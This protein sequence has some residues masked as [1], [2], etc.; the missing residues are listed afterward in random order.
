MKCRRALG[1]ALLILLALAGSRYPPPAA[2]QGPT[3]APAG[4]PTPHLLPP[5]DEETIRRLAAALLANYHADAVGSWDIVTITGLEDWGIVAIAPHGA[6]GDADIL[7]AHRQ[8]GAWQVALPDSPAFR[9]WLPAVPTELLVPFPERGR[10]VVTPEPTAP[11]LGLYKLPYLCGASAYASRAGADHNNAIDFLI[12]AVSGTDVVVAAEAGWVYRIAQN[13]TACCCAAGYSSNSVVI[14]HA[15]GEYSYYL[16]LQAG[17]VLVQPG[18]Q[19]YQG[20]PIALEGD[21]GYTCSTATGSCHSRFCDVPGD[22]D[23][24]CE[25][26][27]FEVRTNGDYGGVAL[28]PRFADVAGEFVQTGRTYTSGN[29]P[30]P[31]PTTTHTFS[32]TPGDAP[33]FL[34]PVQVTLTAQASGG[35]NVLAT[36]YRL[37]DSD[38]LP[39]AAPFVVSGEGEHALRYYSVDDCGNQETPGPAVPLGIDLHDP[40]NPTAAAPGCRGENNL[41]QDRCADASFTWSGAGDIGSGLRDYALYWGPQPQGQPTAYVTSPA[42]DPGPVPEGVPYFLRLSARDQAGRRA[43]AATL[44]VLRYDATPPAAAL[45]IAGGLSTTQQ[46]A[47]RLDI[48]AADAG[49]G[50]AEMRLSDNGL[51]W[52]AWQPY[53]SQ[54]TWALPALDGRA[55]TVSLQVRDRAGNVGAAADSIYLDLTPPPPHSPGFRLCSSVVDMGGGAGFA[56]PGFRLTA[57]VGQ[58][59]G[60]AAGSSAGFRAGSGFLAAVGGCPPISSSAEPPTLTQGVVAAGGGLRSGSTYRLGDTAG[61]AAVSSGAASSSPSYRLAGGFWAGIG[62]A[63]PPPPTLPTPT[64]VFPPTL[65]PQPTPTRPPSDFGL[66]INDGAAFTNRAAVTLTLWAPGVNR[67]RFSNTADWVGVLWES[68]RPTHTWTISTAGSYFEPRTVFAQ[69]RDAAGVVYGDY[70]DGILYDPVPPTGTVSIVRWGTLTATVRLRA[71]DDNSGVGWMRLAGDEPGL[72]AAPWEPFAPT[73]VVTPTAGRVYAQFR[74]RAGNLSAP[75]SAGPERRVYLPL[76]ER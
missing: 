69:F 47:V 14:R 48:A 38:W 76:V 62:G 32:G 54:S 18:A 25:H 70:Q 9:A 33:W 8:D 50:P 21:V 15:N 11:T 13:Y 37:D 41:W 40:R 1:L 30:N 31:G 16:H 46:V 67:A 24:C 49:S 43:P 57:A 35:C 55:Y 39:Y 68:H 26:L 52:S 72:I 59:W 20:Q 60:G 3:P 51:D 61:E 71:G 66:A 64:P 53:A 5:A 56:S 7:I 73:A 63:V 45:S 17:S 22:Y 19:V 58:P 36:Y 44:F 75:A 27:H 12:A 29:C 4:C 65:R 2:A 10:F 42:Y 28:E 23:Y 6:V 34:S 74:D